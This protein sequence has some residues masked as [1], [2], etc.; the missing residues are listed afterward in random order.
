MHAGPQAYHIV[1]ASKV[2]VFLLD[3]EQSYRDSE[4]T[5]PARI[6]ALAGEFKGVTVVSSISLGDTQFRCG[7][8]KEYVTW[9][10]SVLAA[11]RVPGSASPHVWRRQRYQQAERSQGGPFLL[12]MVPDPLAL[13][14]CLREH[15]PQTRSVRLVSSYARRWITKG[16]DPHASAN[17]ELD[18]SIQFKR[19]N[20][21][22]EWRRAWN[23]APEGEYHRFVQAPVGTKIAEDPLAEVGCPYVVRGFDFDYIGLLWLSDLV[24]RKDRWWFNLDTIH[25]SAWKGTRARARRELAAER[26]GTECEELLQRLKRGYRVLLTRAVRGMY[27]WVEDA[28]TREY[29]GAALR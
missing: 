11:R 17:S 18:F 13:D 23:F 21:T 19:G 25:E 7:G 1:R 4:T 29:L 24:W 20:R 22:R 5:T 26:P 12:E 27:I 28:E 6:Q 16:I 9:V 8:S 14:E 3:P 2:S 15:L 10:E